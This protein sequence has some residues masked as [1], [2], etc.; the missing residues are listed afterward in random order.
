LLQSLDS[1][2]LTEWMAYEQIE[3]FGQSMENW[4]MA[5]ICCTI[6]NCHRGKNDKVFKVEDFMPSSE[7]HEQTWEDHLKLCKVLEAAFKEKP[8][9]KGAAK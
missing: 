5:M 6:A 7:K 3:P 2:E 9:K 8:K 1:K 4:R